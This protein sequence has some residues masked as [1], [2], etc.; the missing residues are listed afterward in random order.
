MPPKRTPSPPNRIAACDIVS[1]NPSLSSSPDPTTRRETLLQLPFVASLAMLLTAGTLATWGCGPK[2]VEETEPT[3]RP[4][5]PAQTDP[6]EMSTSSTEPAL[7][8]P[9]LRTSPVLFSGRQ[10]MPVN[11]PLNVSWTTIEGTRS[12]TV[13]LPGQTGDYD[14]SDDGQWL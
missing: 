9:D 11:I 1:Q 8:T 10:A 6:S 4:N 12:G 2:S 13:S 5:S 7:P 14:W 3:A